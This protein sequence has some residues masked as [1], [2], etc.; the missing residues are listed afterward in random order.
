MIQRTAEEA[1]WEATG[2]A[3]RETVRR[4]FS[5]IAD[6][7]DRLNG[8]LSLRGHHRWRTLAVQALDLKPSDK[9]LDV[10]SGTGDFA[11]ALQKAI[12]DK[13]LV[14]GIDF[15]G[16][17]LDIAAQKGLKNLGMGDACNL[18]IQD[19]VFDAVTVGWGIRNVPD[20]DQAHREIARVLKPGGRFVSLDMA[21][22]RNAFIGTVSRML[23]R[24]GSPLL[25]TIFSKKSAYQY[26]PLSTE[27]FWSREELADSMARVGFVRVRTKDFMFGNICMHWGVKG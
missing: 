25:G 3:K 13:G 7:Y 17:M 12:S 16:P 24:L 14:V 1:P 26:L 23:F 20:I 4:M 10:C 22:P 9:A 27:R 8:I 5:E 15:C 18:P 19:E 11:L 2:Q 21:R 6:T